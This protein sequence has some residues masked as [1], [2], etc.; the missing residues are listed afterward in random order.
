MKI[1][2]IELKDKNYKCECGYKDWQLINTEPLIIVCKHCCKRIDNDKF[3][4]KY[5]EELEQN[6]F[7]TL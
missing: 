7:V 3:N 5:D 4:I 1:P 2:V 6:G